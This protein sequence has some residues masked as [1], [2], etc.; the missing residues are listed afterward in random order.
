MKIERHHEKGKE[1]FS[2]SG[3]SNRTLEPK[4][5]KVLGVGKGLSRESE[6]GNRNPGGGSTDQLS[7][8]SKYF[9]NTEMKPIK[10]Y[11]DL[12]RNAS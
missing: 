11:S 2:R 6:N 12:N 5:R 10:W 9:L 3:Q 4:G 1:I 8:V 7:K